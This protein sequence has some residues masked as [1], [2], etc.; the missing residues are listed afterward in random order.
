MRPILLRLRN[1]TVY[2]RE[3][4]I[5]FSDLS[6][7]IIQG[8]TGS[9]KTSLIDAICYALYGKVP[10]H[11]RRTGIHEQLLSK[12]QKNM[13]VYL[14]FSVKGKRYAVDRI[15][16]T[17]GRS[18]VRFYEGSKLLNLRAREVNDHISKLIGMDY[19]TFTK[20]LVLPQ[21]QFDKLLKPEEPRERREVLNRILGYDEVFKRINEIVNRQVNSLKEKEKELDTEYNLT[22]DATEGRVSELKEMLTNMELRHKELVEKKRYLGRDLE[23]ANEKERKVKSLE[24]KERELENL[25]QREE[26]VKKK[27]DKLKL[28]RE[29]SQYIH[30]LDQYNKNEEKLKEVKEERKKHELRLRICTEEVENV[31]EEFSK[32]EQQ[33]SNIDDFKRNSTLLERL[34]DD[35]KGLLNIKEKITK[36]KRERDDMINKKKELQ[37][38]IEELRE[39][40]ERGK[41]YIR[42]VKEELKMLEKIEEDYAREKELKRQV[43][44]LPKKEEELEKLEKQYEEEEKELKD[45]QQDI[46]KT[47]NKLFEA[48]I[49]DIR[50]KL[51]VNSPCP[52]CGSTVKEVIKAESLEIDLEALKR[53]LEDLRKK[54]RSLNEKIGIH[55]GRIEGLSNSRREVL[56]RIGDPSRFEA[57]FKELEKKYERKK[58]LE[59]KKDEAEELY[60]E[61]ESEKS[62][63]EMELVE[64]ESN[65]KNLEEAISDLERGYDDIRSKASGVLGR[66][67][68]RPDL[69]LFYISNKKKAL[70]EKIKEIKEKYDRLRDSKESLEKEIAILHT[71][72][73]QLD[74]QENRLKKERDEVSLKLYPALERFGDIDK[75]REFC[76]SQ[77]EMSRLEAELKDYEVRRR[78]LEEAVERLQGEIESY[79]KELETDIVRKELEKVDMELQSLNQSIGAVRKERED[80]EKKLERRRKLEKDIE[81]I[82]KGLRVYEIIKKDMESD[83]FPEFVS[84]HM[85]RTIVERAS[86]YLLKFSSG[87]YEFRFSN[88][89]LHVLERT[90]GHERSVYTLSGGETFLASLSLAFGVSDIVSHNAPLESIFIDEGFGSLDRETRES[91]GDFFEFIKLNAGR[92]VGIISHIEDLAEKFDQRIIVERRG[93]FSTI[94]VE[95]T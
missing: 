54:E 21:G 23:K 73:Q 22:K 94:T 52:V 47:E 43:D 62:R 75:L 42:N 1:F 48:Y 2:K 71:T 88:G 72:L 3:L 32:A 56:D 78:N 44:D 35:L 79:P 38:K 64:A 7:F 49:H 16:E 5:D 70:D 92:M 51:S 82:K 46:Y 63:K 77:E 33:Y 65:L 90:T 25:I 93:D 45:V 50:S 86:Y 12:G 27:E 53:H 18:E 61:L 69:D 84:Q 95:A 74:E 80:V 11:N 57:Y 9:G 34:E 14:E 91:L 68:I 19:N 26:E 30:Y 59:G 36:K 60:R 8:R 17:S 41:E 85:L 81:S 76:L 39:R 15:Y 89:D 67:I 58:E 55:K 10:R 29:V 66:E 24:E 87:T 4:E 37:N 13:R 28:A 31:R 6:F 20:V 40:L 83:R